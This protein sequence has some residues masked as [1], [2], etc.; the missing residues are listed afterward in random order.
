MNYKLI[1]LLAL[2]FAGLAPAQ[3]S[4]SGKLAFV[5]PNLYGLDGLRL[6]NPDH[7]A[8]FNSAFQ[9]N[10][11]PLN[12]AIATQL[13]S[14][15]IPSPA[16]GF[17]Y[18][19]DPQLGIYDRSAASF[20][21]ILAERAET[22]GKNKFYFGFAMQRFTFD[23]LDQVDLHQF[24][25]VFTHIPNPDTT[26]AFDL[27]TTSNFV[28]LSIGQFTSYFTYGLADRLDLSVA[29]PLM[30][31]SLD[32]VSDATI[33]RIGSADDPGVPHTFATPPQDVTQKRFANSGEASGLGDV[34]ARLKGT[35]FQSDKAGVALG[36]DLR[37]PTG[38]QYNF[39]GSGAYGVKPFVALSTRF[40]K[41][42]P[43][44]NLAYQWNGDSVL[45]GDVTTGLKGAIP[46]QTFVIAGFD[47]GFSEKFTFAADYLSQRLADAQSIEQT[48]FTA[49]NGAQFVNTSFSTRS[50]W[51][52]NAALG[53]KINPAGS[54]LV[55]FNVLLKL[56]DGGLRDKVTPLIGLS[57]T[58]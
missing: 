31:A 13:T 51:I 40:G 6:P 36:L 27:I 21:P 41:V 16:S 4:S 38:D 44:V 47:V 48:V 25:S 58:L 22:I 17:T 26:V 9:G 3:S 23:E 18:S 37:V 20:G 54:L 33:Q 8:H 28:D 19:F 50:F 46:E 14:L 49:H 42:S 45:A 11:G 57:Y 30:S 55:N 5:I 12:A 15:P 43:H 53:F 52:R 34:I 7:E 29:V 32:V 56:N 2:A 24:P 10:F 35:V 39:L 1:P